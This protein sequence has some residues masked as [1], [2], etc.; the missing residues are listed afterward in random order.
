MASQYP[1]VTSTTG[2]FPLSDQSFPALSTPPSVKNWS[3]TRVPTD[4]CVGLIRR[5]VSKLEATLNETIGKLVDSGMNPCC[6][7][8]F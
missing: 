1:Q 3:E 4:T 2:F 6:I 7:L 5:S 8:F